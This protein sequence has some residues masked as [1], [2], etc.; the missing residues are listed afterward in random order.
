MKAYT[1]L[2]ILSS[3]QTQ[4]LR[5]FR[6]FSPI[7]NED[8]SDCTWRI[9]V[10]C[11]KTEHYQEYL[12]AVSFPVHEKA[13]PLATFITLLMPH[14]SICYIKRKKKKKKSVKIEVR[15]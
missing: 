14:L 8:R 1:L 6:L 11:D 5:K 2:Y 10:S 7:Q 13:L 9:K 3:V 4:N 15:I 12:V